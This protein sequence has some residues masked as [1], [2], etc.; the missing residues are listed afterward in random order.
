MT[1]SAYVVRIDDPKRPY[2]AVPL[3]AWPRTDFLADAVI[4]AG[5]LPWGTPG[6]FAVRSSAASSRTRRYDAG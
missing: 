2:W 5:P 3:H 6:I 4:V 1:Q